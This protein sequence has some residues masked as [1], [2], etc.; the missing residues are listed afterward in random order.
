M[1]TGSPP[2]SRLP[3]PGYWLQAAGRVERQLVGGTARGIITLSRIPGTV[4]YPVSHGSRITTAVPSAQ[5]DSLN[6]ICVNINK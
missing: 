5:E 6:I 4:L 3:S 1:G 2:P